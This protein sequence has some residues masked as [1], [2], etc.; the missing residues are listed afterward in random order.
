VAVISGWVAFAEGATARVEAWLDETPLGP[1]RLGLPRPDAAPVMAGPDAAIRGFELKAALIEA[2]GPEREALLRVLAESTAG[3]RREFEPIPVRVGGEP[4]PAAPAPPRARSRLSP[5]GRGRRVLAFTNVLTLG[6][7]SIYFAEFLRR[8]R[9]LER[10]APTVVTAID[11]PLRGELEAEG[12]PVHLLGP[13]ALDDPEAYGDRIQELAAWAAPAGFELV[14]VNTATGL[15]LPGAD[16]AAHLGIPAVWAI[17]E[18]F[19][20]A[21]LW[22]G[23]APALR[24]RAERALGE[25]A[26]AVFEAEA[27]RQLYVGSIPPERSVAAPYGIEM[28]PIEA[29]RQRFDHDRARREA[30]LPADAELAICVGTVEP[31]KA[32]VSLLQAFELI[33]ESNPRARLAFVGAT[34]NA[35]S[36]LLRDR[37]AASPQR[38]RVLIVPQER[39]VGPWY[40]MADLLVCASDVESLP[41]VVLEAMA[42]GTPVLATAV[43]GLA[44]LI[45]HGETGWLCEPGDVAALAVGLG[46]ALETPAAGRRQIG[47]AG[48]R[49][50]LERHDLD[51]YTRRVADLF[52]RAA[53]GK[54]VSVGSP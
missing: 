13:V 44:E 27:T 28:A 33:A 19:P 43:F 36:A 53:G 23:L 16:L 22:E 17:H 40:G 35:G 49:L 32:Q 1:A 34:E 9:E 45:E 21:L 2:P 18:S 31:R 15:T 29:A 52:D 12:V 42:W 46:T 51:A 26:L 38:D 6:G 3:E 8:A 47:E 10:L 14:F 37:V 41:R 7:A 4:R 50:I 54:S 25:A 39:D 11:G 48:R 5:A 24:E 20:A 30:G